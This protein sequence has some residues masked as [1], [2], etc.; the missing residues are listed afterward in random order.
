MTLRIDYSITP[1]FSI[2]FYGAP[3]VSA[4]KFYD[5]KEAANPTAEN[6]YERFSIFDNNRFNKDNFSFDF[7]SDGEFEF[8]LGNR[9]FNYKQFRSNL[10][11]RWEY[12][13][14]SVLFIVWSHEQNDYQNT[15]EFNALN[16]FKNL[17]KSISNDNILIKFQ[18]RFA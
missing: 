17:F 3:F 11:L 15:G 16:D 10:I 9:D 1:D 6:Y 14:G 5:F 18:Y 8:V 7:D 12:I 13:P 2:Q 4:A